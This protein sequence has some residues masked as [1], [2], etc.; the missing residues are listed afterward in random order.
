MFVC[1]VNF[2]FPISVCHM[3]NNGAI[4]AGSALLRLWYN[5]NIRSGDYD[6]YVDDDNFEKCRIILEKMGFRS[7]YKHYVSMI[8]AHVTRFTKFNTEIDLVHCADPIE[9]IIN[10]DLDICASF[11]LMNGEKQMLHSL[12]PL[13]YHEQKKFQ[14]TMDCMTIYNVMRIIKYI[15]YGYE[16]YD[17]TREFLICEINTLLDKMSESN[18][19][20]KPKIATCHECLNLLS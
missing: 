19:F 3:L 12:Q 20:S 16:P 6:L 10:T 15:H 5:E 17:E 14:Y 7:E 1:E 18:P 9:T 4:L 13:D 11:M 2:V 8:D